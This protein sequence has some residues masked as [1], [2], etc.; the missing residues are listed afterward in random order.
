MF[1]KLEKEIKKEKIKI[2]IPKL[3]P[4]HKAHVMAAPLPAALTQPLSRPP[5]P[6]HRRHPWAPPDLS[7]THALPSPLLSPA[8]PARDAAPSR[9]RPHATSQ[10]ASR[11][12]HPTP[13]EDPTAEPRPSRRARTRPARRLPHLATQQQAAS[14]PFPS[15]HPAPTVLFSALW[16]FTASVTPSP[17]SSMKPTPSMELMSLVS[18]LYSA[19]LFLSSPL[20]L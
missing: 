17:L 2:K 13:T 19:P 7:P 20:S 11:P 10:A 6:S 8:R 5:V 18:S 9:S 1:L 4:N 3:N 15:R 14:R 16:S 12:E